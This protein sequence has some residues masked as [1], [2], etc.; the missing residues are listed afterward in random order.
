M[1]FLSAANRVCAARRASFRA[2]RLSLLVVTLDRVPQLMSHLLPFS[3]FIKHIANARRS[4]FAQGAA[5]VPDEYEFERMKAY[6]L[7]LYGGVQVQHSFELPGGIVFDCVPIDE[8]PGVRLQNIGSIAEPPELGPAPA[9]NGHTP[10]VERLFIGQQ[11]DPS[12]KDAHGNQ[13][14]CP[15]GT[16]PMRRVSVEDIVRFRTLEEFFRK[17]PPLVKSHP[18]SHPLGAGLPR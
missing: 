15:K 10:G 16:I 18:R 11:V 3:A 1:R 7:Q 2:G 8:Q 6:V 4:Q 14:R 9:P 5:V 13:C 12:S 17:K